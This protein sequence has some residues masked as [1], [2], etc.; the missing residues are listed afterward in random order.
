M[1]GVEKVI[2][3]A[4]SPSKVAERL[5]AHRE[6]SRQLVEYWRGRGYIPGKWAPIVHQEFGTA[7]HE[8]NPEV[9]PQLEI[10]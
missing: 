10:Q 6:C 2:E 8:L 7:L 1:N 9:Y 3:A 4:G 5:S